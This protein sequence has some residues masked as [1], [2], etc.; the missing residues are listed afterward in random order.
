MI[1]ATNMDGKV[2][3]LPK[4][5]CQEFFKIHDMRLQ[6]YVMYLHG[7]KFLIIHHALEGTA[8]GFKQ[9][10]ELVSNDIRDDPL[11]GSICYETISVS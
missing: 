6:D 5:L 4:D 8:Q 3:Q 7:T 10:F 2:V 9:I 11:F 1:T